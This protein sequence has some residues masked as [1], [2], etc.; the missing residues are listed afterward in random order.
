MLSNSVKILDI[1]HI[2]E[3]ESVTA[4]LFQNFL[5]EQIVGNFKR[6]V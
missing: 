2:V 3:S 1:N 5:I 6:Y 4:G